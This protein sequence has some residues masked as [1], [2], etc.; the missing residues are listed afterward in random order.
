MVLRPS[1]LIVE[2]IERLCF[3]SPG[4]HASGHVRKELHLD[5]LPPLLHRMIYAKTNVYNSQRPYI[6]GLH[7]RRICR[8]QC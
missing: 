2:N 8:I 7:Q 5:V 4:H 3:Q 6:Y 1:L